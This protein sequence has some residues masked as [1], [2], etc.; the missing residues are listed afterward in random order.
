MDEAPYLRR[1]LRIYR[2]CFRDIEE[3][4]DGESWLAQSVRRVLD[5]AQAKVDRLK[6]L[7]PASVLPEQARA[8]AG[9]QSLEE[10]TPDPHRLPAPRPALLIRVPAG[11]EGPRPGRDEAPAPVRRGGP[12]PLGPA[13]LGAEAV[14]GCHTPNCGREALNAPGVL[15]CGPCRFSYLNGIRDTLRK[16]PFVADVADKTELCGACGHFVHP[17]GPCGWHG[18][19]CGEALE[20]PSLWCRCDSVH[21]MGLP[22]VPR[23]PCWEHVEPYELGAFPT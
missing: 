3:L 1:L 17:E 7:A 6:P 16:T 5:A 11:P 19:T 14:S 20:D 2:G 21:P 23:D 10:S 12:E 13:G 22:I 18:G 4:A 15:L 9:L 8:R